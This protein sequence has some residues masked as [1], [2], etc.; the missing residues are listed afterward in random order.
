MATPEGY[1]IGGKN[2]YYFSHMLNCIYD[3]RY[4]FLQGMYRSAHYVLFVNYDEFFGAMDAKLMAH[5]GEDVW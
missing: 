3:C 5:D 1:G 2:N 4:C